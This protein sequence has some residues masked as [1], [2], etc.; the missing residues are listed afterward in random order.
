MFW[1]DNATIV[2]DKKGQPIE[3]MEVNVFDDSHQATLT[4]WSDYIASAAAWKPSRTILLLKNAA[5]KTV[6]KPT[7]SI[8]ASTQVNV[9]P[10]M[11]DAEWL[12]SFAS[13][14]T[15]RDHVNVDIPKDGNAAPMLLL[16]SYTEA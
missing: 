3:K 12:R 4:L 9:D 14:M 11:R 1:S 5:Y 15:I 13:T 2:S 8:T 6:G 10:V 7:I 16:N